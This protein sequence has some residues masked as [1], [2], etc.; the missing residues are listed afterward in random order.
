M[1]KGGT[2]VGQGWEGPHTLCRVSECGA[3]AVLR[4]SRLSS[5]PTASVKLSSTDTS[6]KQFEQVDQH[7]KLFYTVSLILS[8]IVCLGR[9]NLKNDR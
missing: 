7:Y 3:V 2:R 8:V 5:P 1:K 9:E 6:Q 4:S